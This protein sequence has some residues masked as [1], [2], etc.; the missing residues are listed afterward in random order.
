M[1]TTPYINRLRAQC[2]GFKFIGG[3]LDLNESTLLATT[4]PAAFVLPMGEHAEANQMTG[5]HTQLLHQSWGVILTLKAVRTSANDQSAELQTLRAQ[6]RSALMGWTPDADTA[7]LEFATG[8]LISLES[9]LLLWQDDF[10][11]STY[12]QG[13]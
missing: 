7:P 1:N 10:T 12:L 5:R 2:P 6:I 3:A 13:A 9:G 8:Q 4:Y 11:T